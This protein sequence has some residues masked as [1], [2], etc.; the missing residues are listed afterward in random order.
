MA[1]K[2]S[3]SASATDPTFEMPDSVFSLVWFFFVEIVIDVSSFWQLT[4]AAQNMDRN[5]GTVRDRNLPAVERDFTLCG[6][7][8]LVALI[9]GRTPPINLFRD[10]RGAG[11]PEV[12]ITETI[13]DTPDIGPVDAHI[14]Q[15]RIVHRFEL[16]DRAA[17]LPPAREGSTQLPD[18]G[19][20]VIALVFVSGVVK[21]F[22]GNVDGHFFSS[23]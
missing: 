16:G 13:H 5:V 10:P 6:N 14:P 9:V 8:A 17:S 20:R 11:Q 21:H 15:K 19:D 23:S 7:S 2:T 18:E 3:L 1:A 4:C 22:A 12:A